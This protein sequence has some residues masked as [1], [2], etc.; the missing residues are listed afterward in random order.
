MRRSARPIIF[1]YRPDRLCDSGRM[2]LGSGRGSE[3][4][5]G[6][7][8]ELPADAICATRLREVYAYWQGLCRSLGHLPGRQDIDPVALK[9]HLPFLWMVDAVP[10]GHGMRYRY[11]LI[12]TEIVAARGGDD[13]GKFT[14]EVNRE[15][16]GRQDVNA[17]FALV[18]Q[19]GRAH[20]RRGPPQWVN[21]IG[22]RT[23]YIET[24]YMPLAATDGTAGIILAVNAYLDHSLREIALYGVRRRVP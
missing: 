11:R 8:D 12:G 17:R 21:I 22:D 10:A 4:R 16:D 14:D 9:A 15:L 24:I 6:F 23:P 7:C 5:S 13:T 20:W 1:L 19:S 18:L 2:K 3:T